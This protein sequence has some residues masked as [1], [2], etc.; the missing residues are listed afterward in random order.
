M[1]HRVSFLIYKQS[2]KFNLTYYL[3]YLPKDTELTKKVT[4]LDGLSKPAAKNYV[5][6]L[7]SKYTKGMFSDEYWNGVENIWKALHD[8]NV[9]FTVSKSDYHHDEKGVP[10]S[11]TWKFQINFNDNR[12]KPVILY[13]I[14]TAAGA[15]TV[16][17]PLSKYDLVAYVS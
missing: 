16:S 4:T 7:L 15:G 1:I 10:T 12:E 5:N 3:K 6:K 11:K 14:V 17:E 9:D 13:G 8:E 2:Y